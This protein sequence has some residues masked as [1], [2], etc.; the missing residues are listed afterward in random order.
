MLAALSKQSGQMLES[1]G[2]IL[3]TPGAIA[4]GVLAGDPLSGF[5]FDYDTRTSGEEL[6]KSYGVDLENPIARTTAGLATEI[7]TDP[8]AWFTGGASAINK[9]GRAAKAA[10]VLDLAPIV[11][12][13]KMGLKAASQTMTGKSVAR[14]LAKEGVLPTAG[15]LKVRPLVG[16]RLART[17]ATLDE[18]VQQAIDPKEALRQAENYLGGSAEYAKYKDQPVGSLF[19]FG[20]LQPTV[21]GSPFSTKTTETILDALDMTGDAIKWSTPARYAAAFTNK[22]VEGFTGLADQID[23]L[24]ASNTAEEFLFKGRAAA[25][26]HAQKLQQVQLDDQA[27]QM[28]GA[29]TLYSPQG[30]D[31]L[32]R[33]A[34][35]KPTANDLLIKARLPKLQEW[36]DNWDM[37]RKQS[38]AD[39]QRLGLKATAL[40]DTWGTEFSPR[41]GYEFDYGEFTKGTGKQVFSTRAV[42]GYERSRQMMLPGGTM[43]LREIS[44]LPNIRKLSSKDGAAITDEAA[45]R[46][47]VDYIT[48][49]YGNQM[50]TEK[51][52]TAIARVMRKLNPNLPVDHPLF[53]EHPINAHMRF[54]VDSSLRQATAEHIYDALSEAAES[55]LYT[56]KSG[57][58]YRSLDNAIDQ[59]AKQTGMM[60]DKNQYAHGVVKNELKKRIAQRLGKNVNDIDLTQFAVP[61]SVKDRLVRIGDFYS[62]PRAQ[63]EVGNLLN[64][65]TSVFKGFILAWPSRYSRDFVSNAASAWLETGSAVD[66]VTG[67]KAASNALAGKYDQAMPFLQQIPRYAGKTPDEIRRLFEMDV[68]AN[69]VL[70]GLATTDL[71]TANRSGQISQFLPGATPVTISGGLND[72][73]PQGNS[74]GQMASDFFQIKN[75]TNQF[76]TRNPIL[77]SGQKIGDAVDSIGRLGTFMALLKQGVGPQQAA[78]RVLRS[79][80]DYGSLTTFERHWMRNIFPWYSYASRQG[81]YVADSLIENPGGRYGQMMRALNVTQ[82]P[83]E[84]NYV[85]TALRQQ[86][87]FRLPDAMQYG[88]DVTRYLKLD[89]P[90]IDVI[91]YF[92]P[93][94]S[95]LAPLN[96]Q[97]TLYEFANQSHPL[98]RTT[99]ELATNTDMFS[100]RPLNES[101]TPVDR[102]YKALTGSE[103]RVNPVA[104]AV[105]QNIPGLQRP[106]SLFGALADDRIPM[107]QRLTKAGINNLTPASEQIVDKNYELLDASRKLG[108]RLRPYQ[109]TFTQRYIPEELEPELPPSARMDNALDKQI[110]QRLQRAY[111]QKR[112]TGQLEAKKI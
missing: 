100:K 90:G 75:V 11:A 82:R 23:A 42:S 110:K 104:K 61:E 45:G 31:M 109:N 35:G 81:K 105:I 5:S 99:A 60:L 66:T 98:L 74:V 46:E 89:P 57:R 94:S 40:T 54:M 69:G 88:G 77:T 102:I 48:R 95:P 53:A 26:E 28:L 25:T 71:L 65:F 24:K 63:Q 34:E 7:A 92:R 6:L 36:I 44:M 107:G 56:Q 58:V 37:F 20:F 85:P 72:L 84:E 55:G 41:Y 50:I 16:P 2:L 49:K 14:S 68:G 4:R 67:F 78:Q 39:A 52:G 51:Q 3:D 10:N 70:S 12:Q 96:M 13:N 8:L 76:E 83:D 21:A 101:V 38:L 9:A 91:N 80:V 87:A 97:E 19:G 29:D 103:Q 79:L 22:K 43:D 62:S 18:L 30:N 1:L 15:N 33:F 86:F 112:K 73:V 64:S 111:E 108:D 32:L 47:I 93:G 27:K 106:L 59:V 17:K